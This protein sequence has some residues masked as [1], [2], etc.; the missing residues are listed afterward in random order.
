[1]A[2]AARVAHVYTGVLPLYLLLA[3]VLSTSS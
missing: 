2:L 3:K 1:M